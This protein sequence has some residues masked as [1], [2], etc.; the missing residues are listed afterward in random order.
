MTGLYFSGTGNTKYCVEQ[1]VKMYGDSAEAFS[2]EDENVPSAISE[3]DILVIGYPVQYSCIPKILRDYIEQH[4][5][6][7]HGKKVYIIATMAMF[8]GDGAGVLSRCLRKYGA[9]TIGGLHLIMP[10]SIC[11]EKVLKRPLEENR[12]LVAAASEKIR[13]AAEAMKSGRPAKDGLG[14]GSRMLGFLGQRLLFGGKT[15]RYSSKLKIAAD[16]CVGCGKCVEL[17]PMNNLSLRDGCAVAQG[18]CTMC[19][20]CIAKCPKGAITL[21][22]KSVVEQCCLEKYI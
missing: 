12:A 20:R 10:D 1:F 7:W 16:K 14:I 18:Q 5:D 19:Y 21:L 13:A 17:C 3:S 8:S 4:R 9:E 22:G 2:I 11:D 15:R 6:L